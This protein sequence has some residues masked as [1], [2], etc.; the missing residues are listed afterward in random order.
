MFSQLVGALTV[1]YCLCS[2]HSQD[3][4]DIMSCSNIMFVEFQACFWDASHDFVG[5]CRRTEF[6]ETLHSNTCHLKEDIIFPASKPRD[7]VTRVCLPGCTIKQAF[8]FC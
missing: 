5:V 3:V 6:H 7:T 8:F 1:V 4:N 2:L